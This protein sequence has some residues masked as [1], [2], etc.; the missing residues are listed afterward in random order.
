MNESTSLDGLK[1]LE[2]CIHRSKD[3]LTKSACCG[4]H[5]ING[6]LCT[7][8]NIFPISYSSNCMNCNDYINVINYQEPVAPPPPDSPPPPTNPPV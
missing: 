7:K 6:F 3:L 8:N 2:T 5:P 4:G 1:K